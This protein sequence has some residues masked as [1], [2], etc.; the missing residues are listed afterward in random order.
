MPITVGWLD[1]SQK[2]VLY[3]IEGAWTLEEAMIGLEE[4]HQLASPPPILYLADLTKAKT[5]PYG[6]IGRK[7]YIS[8]YLLPT[9][10]LTVFLGAHPL[11]NFFINALVRL[12]VPLRDLV[13]VNTME[14][15]MRLFSRY[16]D[17]HGL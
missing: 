1:E 5:V 6:I 15:A 7:D 13:F 11:L 2:I 8:K 14:E 4:S 9:E 16:S 12:G 10:G 3:R 17:E